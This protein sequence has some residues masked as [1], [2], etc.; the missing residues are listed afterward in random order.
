MVNVMFIEASFDELDLRS[1]HAASALGWKASRLVNGSPVIVKPGQHVVS[2]LSGVHGDERSGPFYLMHLLEDWA[3]KKREVPSVGMIIVPVLNDI[4][5]KEQRRGW[6]ELDLNRQFNDATIVHHLKELMTMYKELSPVLHW[7]L[8]ED[9]ERTENYVFVHES[10]PGG[11]GLE[12]AQKLAC[13]LQ[14]WSLIDH[15][16]ECFMHHEIGALAFTTEANPSVSM[17]ERFIWLD[18]IYE[19]FLGDV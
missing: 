4:G 8:H 1:M 17:E 16:S 14:E 13:P 5:W 12:L 3:S 7:D 10:D 6:A 19:Y 15:A 9:D 2:L 11:I 18:R